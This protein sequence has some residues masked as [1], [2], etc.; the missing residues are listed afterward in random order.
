LPRS[1][2]NLLATH[3]IMINVWCSNGYG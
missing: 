2:A 3:E 1:P